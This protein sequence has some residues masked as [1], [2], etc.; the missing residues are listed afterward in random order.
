MTANKRILIVDDHG[1]FRAGLKTILRRDATLVVVGEA[2]NA[3]EGIKYALECRPNIVLLDISLPGRS[4][5]DLAREIRMKLP[6][7]LIIMISTFSQPDIVRESVEAGAVGYVSKVSTPET[8]LQCIQAVESGQLFVDLEASQGFLTSQ[9][10]NMHRMNNEEYGKLSSREQEVLRMI[11]EGVA[12]HDIAERL[13]ISVKTV[14][15]HRIN[16]LHKLGLKTTVDLVK[17]AARIG[18]IDLENWNR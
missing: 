16:V 7:A 4:G 12:P 9:R 6:S 13:F 15:N 2:N 14:E 10:H 8:L 11:A 1:L 5:L 17:Y 18:I 3:D